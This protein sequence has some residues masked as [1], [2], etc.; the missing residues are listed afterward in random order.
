MKETDKAIFLHR[1]HYSESSLII[2]FY[3]FKNGIQKFLFQGGKKKAGGLFPLALSEIHYYRRPDSELGK[4]TQIAPYEM[5]HAISLNPIKSTIAFFIADVFIKCLQTNQSD[6]DLFA[7]AEQKIIS[8]NMEDDLTIFVTRFLLEFSEHLGIQP[9][10]EAI[11]KK[12][13]HLQ[14]GE[15]SD[16]HSKEEIFAEGQAVEL[17]QDILRKNEGGTFTKEIKQEAF[18]IMI[19]YYKLHIPRFDVQKSLDVIREILYN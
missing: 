5:L 14:D 15:F 6:P 12:C 18:E 13:F 1:I 8:L 4:L 7:F 19:L 10:L 9:N 17:L 3:T 16:S 11:N 2:T